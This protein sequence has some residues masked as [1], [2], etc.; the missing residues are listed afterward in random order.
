MNKLLCLFFV[1]F[2]CSCAASN[3]LLENEQIAKE[4]GFS[5]YWELEKQNV[6]SFFVKQVG[7][8][9]LLVSTDISFSADGMAALVTNDTVVYDKTI[10]KIYVFFVKLVDRWNIVFMNFVYQ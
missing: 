8:P 9:V 5:Q 7:F 10:G 3:R 4:N 2:F 6:Q 1:L